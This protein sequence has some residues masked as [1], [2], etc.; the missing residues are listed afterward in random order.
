M[1]CLISEHK[2]NQ[3]RS[4]GTSRSASWKE[5]VT[6][7]FQ[8]LQIIPEKFNGKVLVSFKDGGISYL[9][10]TETLK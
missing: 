6:K 2:L 7:T 3:G 1:T 5:T 8:A 4:A 10:K 9:E